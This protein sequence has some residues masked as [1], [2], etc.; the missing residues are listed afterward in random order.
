LQ[1]GGWTAY[2][3][4]GI[5]TTP[6]ELARWGDQYRAGDIIHDDFEVGAVDQGTGVKYAAGINIEVNGDLSHSGRI[7]GYLTDFTVSK[8]LDTV[9]AVMCNG[10]TSPRTALKTALWKVWATDSTKP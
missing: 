4:S 10:H 2:G 7:E 5:I 9:I 1:V 3:Y 8:D 6:S